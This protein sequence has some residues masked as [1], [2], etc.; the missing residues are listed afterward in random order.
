MRLRRRKVVDYAEEAYQFRALVNRGETEPSKLLDLALAL[1]AQAP[2][3]ED[4]AY[5]N[6]IADVLADAD[7]IRIGRAGEVGLVVGEAWIPQGTAKGL[8]D[9]FVLL[10]VGLPQSVVLRKSGV[11]LTFQLADGQYHIEATVELGIR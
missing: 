2:T 6:R 9:C 11:P 4:R 1:A 3:E 10:G 7:A 8:A 5:W